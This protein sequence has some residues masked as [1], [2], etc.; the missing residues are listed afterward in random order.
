MGLSV[1]EATRRAQIVAATITTLAE[2]GYPRTSF[3][4][5]VQR[6]GL[7]STRMISYHFAGKKDLMAATVGAIVD[8]WDA[9]LAERLPAHAD[10]IAML[11]AQI[12]AEVAFLGAYP[13]HAKALVEIGRHAD[14]DTLDGLVWQDLRTGRMERQLRQG[15]REGAFGGFDAAVMAMAIRQALDG[16]A[17]H[18]ATRPNLDLAVYGRELADLFE[19]ATR[20]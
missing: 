13:E 5:I 11:R 4:R 9:F 1:T 20:A 8:T 10:R 15:Q 7:S 3:A 12:E 6:A 19:R 18:H 14:D 16:V 2:V 17:L